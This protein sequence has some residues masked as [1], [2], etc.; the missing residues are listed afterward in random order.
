MGWDSLVDLPCVEVKATPFQ[1]TFHI[2]IPFLKSNFFGRGLNI[3]AV[4]MV[5]YLWEAKYWSQHKYSR[6]KNS[7]YLLLYKK[8][9]Q[10]PNF[11]N[12]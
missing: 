6:V 10:V 5:Y 4:R 7:L 3:L 9:Y 11:L 1:G 12:N 8:C 2:Q